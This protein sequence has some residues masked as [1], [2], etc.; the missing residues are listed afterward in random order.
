MDK[1]H[2]GGNDMEKKETLDRLDDL[3]KD[4]ENMRGFKGKAEIVKNIQSSMDFVRSHRLEPSLMERLVKARQ[5]DF[6]LGLE[7]EEKKYAEKTENL[8]S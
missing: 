6:D 7:I 2:K 8:V 1:Q 3:K 4:A 5:N